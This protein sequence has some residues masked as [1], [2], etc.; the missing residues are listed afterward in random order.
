[1]PD[2]A[3]KGNPRGRTIA[4]VWLAAVSVSCAI[5]PREPDELCDKMEAF[6]N[7]ATTSED[8]TVR[9]TTDWGGVFTKSEGTNEEFMYAKSCEHYGYEPGRTLC[10]YLLE[11]TSTEFGGINARRALRCIG[12]EAPGRSPID[13]DRL[14]A[15][16][17]SH[18]V[19]GRRVHSDVLVQFTRAS[20]NSP[21]TL[22]ITAIGRG[23]RR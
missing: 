1:M 21:P 12:V 18:S 4:I 6:A 3:L 2:S 11:S 17:K 22:S 14:P 9:L 10:A 7:A 5:P 23:G 16:A 8:H 13:D 19:L 20:D 15:S